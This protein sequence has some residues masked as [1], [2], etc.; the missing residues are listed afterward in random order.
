MNYRDNN[1]EWV[2]IDLNLQDLYETLKNG[3]Y[4]ETE[5]KIIID[6]VKANKR[7]NAY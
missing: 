5:I 1:G 6:S 4:S 2:K 7:V 3:P